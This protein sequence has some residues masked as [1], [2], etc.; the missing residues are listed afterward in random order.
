MNTGFSLQRALRFFNAHRT[1]LV[2]AGFGLTFFLIQ[3]SFIDDYGVT[4]DEPIHRNWG[5]VFALF[6]H[7][8]DRSVLDMMPGHGINYGPSY[9]FLNFR[10]SEW[11]YHAHFLSFTASNHVLNLLTASIAVGLT[12]V[13]ASRLAGLRVGIF[14][15]IFLSFFPNFIAHAHYNPKDI[16][17]LTAIL[18]SVCML[19]R[20]FRSG[21][22][23]DF[24]LVG[25][26]LGCSLAVK[27]LALVM[28]PAF[29]ISYLVWLACEKHQR[30]N[31]SVVQTEIV[32]M[33]LTSVL[34][35]LGMYVA[36]PSA[37]GDPMLI[38]RSFS[39]FL[40]TDFWPG[41]VLFFAQEYAGADLP[42]FYI[43]FEYLSV[44][45]LLTVGSLFFGFAVL[46]RRFRQASRNPSTVLL[47]LW[48]AFPLA[49]SIKSGL[50]RYDSMRQFFFCLPAIAT[51]AAIGFDAFLILLSRKVSKPRVTA[52]IVSVLLL[53]SLL[54]EV[55]LLHPYEGAYRNEILRAFMPQNIDQM[56]EI[57]YWGSTYKQGIEWLI[58]HAD[59]D[60]VICVPTA[61]VLVTWYQW[62][63]D[64]AFECSAKSTYVMFFTRYTES[65]KFA[66]GNLAPVFVIRRMNSDLLRIYKIKSGQTGA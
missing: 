19:Q 35:V 38:V 47:L 51:V 4:W 5:K 3:F 43:P 22:R 54:H 20:A 44:M 17:L 29:G 33:A 40:Q 52:A 24:A 39:F 45:P 60:P 64:F 36:W 31:R 62:R 37:W 13:F 14:A 55:I 66:L 7:T 2:A 1:F 26:I 48:I 41:R 8:G 28:L 30:L 46:A 65:Q 59:Q 49:L 58:E 63:E 25:L 27:I 18:L 15:V 56:L 16:P 57:E 23:R 34:I 6:L 21:R 42:W 32:T 9:Y 11:L 10:L 53:G 61:G 50:V 12:Y